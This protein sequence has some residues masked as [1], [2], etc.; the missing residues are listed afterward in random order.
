MDLLNFL[1]VVALWVILCCVVLLA[2]SPNYDDGW[3]GKLALGLMAVGCVVNYLDYFEF[4][5]LDLPPAAELL[6]IGFALM[7]VRHL[8]RRLPQL[9]GIKKSA[10]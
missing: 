3:M 9:R 5:S 8:W 1:T 2:L 6:V 7:Q 10:A 4:K